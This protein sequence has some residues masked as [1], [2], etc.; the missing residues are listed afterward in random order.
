LADSPDRKTADETIGEVL[1]PF[2]PPAVAILQSVVNFL[3]RRY[4]S[5]EFFSTALAEFSVKN[6]PQDNRRL[7]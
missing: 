7:F 3:W 4:C 2:W 6:Q 5:E 1:T